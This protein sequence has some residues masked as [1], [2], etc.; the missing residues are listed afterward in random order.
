MKLEH[1]VPWG[2]NLQEYKEMG[3]YSDAD[4]EKKILGCGDGPASVNAELTQEGVKIVSID[5]IYQFSKEQIQQRVEATSKVVSEQLRKNSSDFVWKNIKDVETLIRL[6]LKAMERFLDDYEVGKSA[7]RYRYEELPNIPFTD[8]TFDLA[9]S[10]HFLFLYSEHFDFEFHKRAVFEMLRVAKE[11]RIF[12]ILDLN[13][14]VSKHLN[15]LLVLL[16]ESGYCYEIQKS[17]YEFQ[18]GAFEMLK[19]VG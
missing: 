7:Q 5:P 13:N 3:L 16:K 11:V 8:D 15:S 17:R 4:R 1:V 18:K 14:S 12:P 10:S 6:R 19:I 2:R 9:W